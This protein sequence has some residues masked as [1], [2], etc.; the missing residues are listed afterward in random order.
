VQHVVDHAHEA[1]RLVH[2]GF[3][4]EAPIGVGAHAAERQ[5]LAEQQDLREWRSELVRHARR[6]VRPQTCQLV[7]APQLHQRHR[8]QRGGE[9]Q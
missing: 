9:G 3:H 6:E 7:L 8:S 2:D 4:R 5:R 1:P